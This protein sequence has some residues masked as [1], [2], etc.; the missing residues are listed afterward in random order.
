MG[1]EDREHDNDNDQEENG[2][3]DHR[4]VGSD[5]HPS[6]LH[7]QTRME[8]GLAGP[9]CGKM[10]SLTQGGFLQVKILK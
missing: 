5:L 8:L 2:Q 7:H 6:L 4:G 3:D 9:E 1:E 10:D